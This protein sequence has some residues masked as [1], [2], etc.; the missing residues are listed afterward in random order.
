MDLEIIMFQ[1]LV[2]LT[3]TRIARSLSCVGS[4]SMTEVRGR[5]QVWED[6]G[7]RE[8]GW[9]ESNEYSL[10][11]LYVPIKATTKPPTLYN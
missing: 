10:S 5:L 11:I 9:M 6:N 1:E 2:R 3:K 8:K 4:R 7:R